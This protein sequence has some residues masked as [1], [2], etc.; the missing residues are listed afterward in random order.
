GWFCG[1]GLWGCVGLFGLWVGFVFLF[2]V[3]FVF[4]WFGGG[5][6][7]GVVVFFL[8]WG[9]VWVVVGCGVLVCWWGLGCCW[10]FFGG[11]GRFS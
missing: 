1:F 9:G 7:G 3:C 5:F 10:F 6:G 4:V 8:V 2:G 11:W